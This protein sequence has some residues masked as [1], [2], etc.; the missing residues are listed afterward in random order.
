MFQFQAQ[1]YAPLA[2]HE[3][4][5]RFYTF[6]Q[7][8]HSNCWQY[9]E[10]FKNHVKIIGYCGGTIGDDPGLMIDAELALTNHTQANVM[11]LQVERAKAMAK[12]RALACAFLFGSNKL[13]YRKLLEDLENNFVQGMD[14]YPVT[15]QCTY[16]L[17]VHWKEDPKNVVCLIGGMH[18][19]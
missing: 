19:A 18:D 14:N 16:T 15:L 12:E 4:N 11:N 3:A 13:C 2:L 5:G 8:K 1:Q 6:T 9:Y 10:T 17:L 7:D